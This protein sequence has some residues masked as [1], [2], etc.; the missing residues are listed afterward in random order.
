MRRYNIRIDGDVMPKDFSYEELLMNDI[1]DFDDIEI[2]LVSDC[3][4]STIKGYYFPEEHE[5]EISASQDEN[6]SFTI[7]EFGEAVSNNNIGGVT[8]STPSSDSSTSNASSNNSSNSSTDD[9]TTLKVIFTIIAIIIFIAI[10]CTIG[11]G[12]IPVGAVIYLVLRSIWKD[13]N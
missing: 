12:S 5:D 3:N 13:S 4:W 6:K 1:L 11:W 10:T 2:K 8:P 9:N 7:N